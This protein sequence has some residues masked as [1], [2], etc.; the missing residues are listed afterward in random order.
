[1][2]T[3]LDNVDEQVAYDEATCGEGRR[4]QRED[5][6]QRLILFAQGVG[7]HVSGQHLVPVRSWLESLCCVEP[8]VE[9]VFRCSIGQRVMK[10][11]SLQKMTAG[12][13]PRRYVE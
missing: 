4:G 12:F 2:H 3:S 11:V 13:G 10:V 9:R 6:G 1:M 7:Y 5:V 8:S